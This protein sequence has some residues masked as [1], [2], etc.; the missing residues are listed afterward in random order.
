MSRD[1]E[2]SPGESSSASATA[3]A[4]HVWPVGTLLA[5][6]LS[7]FAAIGLAWL[8]AAV[9]E[10]WA[11]LVVFPLGLG[12]VLAGAAELMRR[13]C[14]AARGPLWG[15][16][17]GWA[18]LVAGQHYGAYLRA[19]ADFE[20][21]MQTAKPLAR[22]ALEAEQSLAPG[23][24]FGEFLVR[25]ARRG[26][27]LWG[28]VRVKDAWAWASWAGDAVLVLTGAIG[29]TYLIRRQRDHRSATTA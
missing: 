23:K 10:S 11:P 22:A 16:A 12:A 9:Q 5:V 25:A 4:E 26:R 24:T 1:A 27:P 19:T 28:D 15:L 7:C 8:A 13:V 21:W 29:A 6:L 18:L 17:A 2:P 14:G 3:A 20:E